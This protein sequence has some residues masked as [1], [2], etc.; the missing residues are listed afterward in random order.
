MRRCLLLSVAAV[1]PMAFAPVPFPR[2]LRG[3]L[4][5]L[6]GEWIQEREECSLFGVSH[7]RGRLVIAGNEA[8]LSIG[9]RP[10]RTGLIAVKGGQSPRVLE[11][12][13]RQSPPMFRVLLKAYRLDEDVL[14]LCYN[15][16]NW[17][18]APRSISCQDGLI[19]E[20]F[21]RKKPCPLSAHRS[22]RRRHP[23]T[24]GLAKVEGE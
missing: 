17:R 23:S 10:C 9:G 11:I 16:A 6:Q 19:L 2:A 14:Q 12:R 15:P 21:R 1:L 22:T 24:R 4:K 7:P 13:Y 18:A 5:A 3:D 8:A 20:T